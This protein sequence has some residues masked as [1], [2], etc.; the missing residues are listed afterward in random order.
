MM[1]G[2][3]ASAIPDAELVAAIVSSPRGPYY[4]KG[5]G[6]RTTMEANNAKWKGMLASFVV[7]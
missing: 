5:V 4:F 3:A 7:Q 1:A 2:Q 6:S